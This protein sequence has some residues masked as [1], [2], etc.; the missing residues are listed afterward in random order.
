MMKAGTPRPFIRAILL[1]AAM[2]VAHLLGQM[3]GASEQPIATEPKASA[4]PAVARKV[5]SLD[6]ATQS[7]DL[8]MK[9]FHGMIT[10][11]F[12]NVILSVD[13][14]GHY[15]IGKVDLGT[16]MAIDPQAALREL[17]KLPHGAETRAAYRYAFNEAP[18]PAGA[19][20]ASTLPPGPEQLAAVLGA[21]GGWAQ[22]DPKAALDWMG[23]L[24]ASDASAMEEA[25][26]TVCE[27][28]PVL[29]S[30][31]INDITDASV[32]NDTINGIIRRWGGYNGQGRVKDPAAALAWLNQAATGATYD[33]GVKTIFEDFAARDP[34]GGAAQ[35]TNLT[36]PADR[37]AAIAQLTKMWGSAQPAAALDWL[38]TLPD[39]DS[40]ART[41]AMNTIVSN[42]SNKSLADATAYVSGSTDPAVFMATA[43][44]LA[45]AMAKTDPQAALTW[46]NS[47]PD[48]A[49]KAQAIS[50]VLTTMA[51]TDFSG[52]W[53]DAT[54]LPAGV[55]RDGA[56]DSLVSTLS[57]TNPVQ[58]AT[59][60]GQLG[61]DAATLSA[62]Q[63]VA[64]NWARQDPA[65]LTTW[66]NAQQP[67]SVRDTA[68]TQYVA[69][70]AASNPAAA[71][72]LA[73]TVD[74]GPL[75]ATEVKTA[76]LAWAKTDLPAATA[77]AQAANLTNSARANLQILLSQGG[78]K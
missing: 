23:T 3:E 77:A 49:T 53:N 38:Q 52:A 47:F 27:R 13:G 34:A 6:R 65:G 40:A 66:I 51:A 60:L 75:R 29:A 35:V 18:E 64:A 5:T 69:V 59:M 63:S 44:I 62:T 20:L 15:F 73:N 61:S 42:W 76:I 72:A 8:M 48:S 7:Y 78:G 30:Q 19:E 28:D 46:V 58:A 33:N 36:D 70:Q 54:N 21:S 71:Y 4:K 45:P 12:G 14:N 24:P 31:Y 22:K 41:T 1:G 25:M 11:K 37:N 39:T 26:L 56:M 9:I 67:G 2:V 57:A 43:P 32:R 74:D 16:L 17:A 10:H 68:V 50:G 55:A